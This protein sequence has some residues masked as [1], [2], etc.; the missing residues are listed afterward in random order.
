MLENISRLYSDYSDVVCFS[1]ATCNDTTEAIK[2]QK[3][4]IPSF[5]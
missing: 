2:K 3:S 4:S 1:L 5:L